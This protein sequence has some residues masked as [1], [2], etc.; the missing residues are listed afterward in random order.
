MTSLLGKIQ[1]FSSFSDN[2]LQLPT[3]DTVEFHAVRSGIREEKRVKPCQNTIRRCG[4]LNCY[5]FWGGKT[6]DLAF[7]RIYLYISTKETVEFDIIRRQVE[8]KRVYKMEF[9]FHH[10]NSFKL[11]IIGTLKVTFDVS[12]LNQ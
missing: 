12:Y 9:T 8:V 7:P 11:C 6:F 5:N 4:I 3:K 10:P 2:Y 1:I